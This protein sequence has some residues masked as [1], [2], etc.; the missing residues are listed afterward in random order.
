MLTQNTRIS[1]IHLSQN[2]IFKQVKGRSPLRA[3][4]RD[5]RAINCF[6]DNRFYWKLIGALK[7]VSLEYRS[8]FYF[9]ANTFLSYT[10][11]I[12]H[13]QHLEN[14]TPFPRLFRLLIYNAIQRER[15]IKLFRF[16]SY[17]DFSV[18]IKQ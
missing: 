16:V 7:I 4:R 12:L 14:N 9:F 17:C 5:A 1:Y 10:N 15:C 8:G 18:F 11:E 13:N 6:Q 3:Y 2:I